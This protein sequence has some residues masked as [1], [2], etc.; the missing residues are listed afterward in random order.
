MMKH[1]L[2]SFAC[3]IGNLLGHVFVE[4]GAFF[5]FLKQHEWGDSTMLYVYNTVVKLT[6]FLSHVFLEFWL[7][8]DDSENLH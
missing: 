6:F 7:V 4:H 8:I 1:F 3:L 5:N 2:I